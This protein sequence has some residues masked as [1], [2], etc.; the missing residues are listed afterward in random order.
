MKREQL[1]HA[2]RAACDI[3]NDDDVVIIGSQSILGQ[4][5]EAPRVLTGSAEVDLYPR[6]RPEMAEVIDAQ[7]GEETGFHHEFGFYLHGVGP[8]TA[9]LPVGWE[10]RLIPVCNANTRQHTGWC[11]EVHD[12]AASKMA[13]P[14]REKDNDFVAALLW[15][16]MASADVLADRVRALPVDDQQIALV[17]ERVQ[18]VTQAVAAARSAGHTDSP[19][20]EDGTWPQVAPP[21]IPGAR[22][23][24]KRSR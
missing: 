17:C 14:Y 6:S 2:I 16:A 5:P 20:Y 24:P 21:P 3:S 9:T 13:F 23:G 7:I 12:L 18:R 11:L 1:E 22:N 19:S 8:E 15:H 10:Q 4:F